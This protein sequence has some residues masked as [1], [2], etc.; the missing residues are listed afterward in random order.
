MYRIAFL[1]LD[2][3]HHVHHILPIAMELSQDSL[4][5]CTV[6]TQ[7][8]NLTVIKQIAKLY[9][10]HQCIVKA[11]SAPWTTRLKYR[12]KHKQ[13]HSQR[14]IK[15]HVNK[16]VQYD[17]IISANGDTDLLVSKSKQLTKKPLFFCT[18]HGAGD[19]P[20][21]IFSD[22][23]AIDLAFFMG[24]K[25]VQR[26]V[27]AGSIEAKKCVIIGYPKFDVIPKEYKPQVF[28]DNKPT[29]IYNPHFADTSSWWRWGL[30]ILEY[31]Y[32]QKQYNFIFAPHTLLF[33]R[34][35]K[36]K[37]LPKKYYHASH[38]VIDLGS[39]KSVDMT[40]TQSADVYLGDISSQVYEFIR[41]PRP[42]IFLN[43]HGIDWR[44]QANTLYLCWGMGPVIDQLPQL[45]EKL[46]TYPLPN[47]YLLIQESLFKKTFSITEESASLRAVNAI[48]QFM[49][50][51]ENSISS[52]PT[53]AKE[54]HYI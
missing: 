33:N 22:M 42:C 35:L 38:V 43:A 9:P 18:Q 11:I 2:G 15:C 52:V 51:R 39:E 34:I 45:W 25:Y 53:A 5:Q 16:L 49:A 7:S 14:I 17:I 40:Y 20:I 1:L 32:N 28:A 6:F 31:F 13:M 3:H 48:R 24:E 27:T 50:T 37:D 54:L 12:L 44:N 29:V 30:E 46:Q 10:S 4:F 23:Q 36:P 8:D 47:P 41:I 26:F 21:N 19:R